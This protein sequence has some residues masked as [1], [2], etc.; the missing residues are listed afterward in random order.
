MIWRMN[1][2]DSVV[3][4]DKVNLIC[5]NHISTLLRS[6]LLIEVGSNIEMKYNKIARY[7]SLIKESVNSL[8]LIHF[9][10]NNISAILWTKLWIQNIHNMEG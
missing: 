6:N 5:K 3:L 7:I 2:W 4:R 1:P 8:M 10:K 9:S